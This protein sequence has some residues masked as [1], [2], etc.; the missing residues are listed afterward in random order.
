MHK[1]V[2]MFVNVDWFFFSHRAII[3]ENAQKYGIEMS[4]FTEFTNPYHGKNAPYRLFNS[5]L[6]RVSIFKISLIKQFWQAF[7][8]IKDSKP[9]LLHAVTIKPII[10]IGLIARITK[11]PFV[12]AIS[13]LG[14][15]FSQQRLQ[16]KIYRYVLTKT[17]KIIMSTDKARVICQN[18]SDKKILIELGVIEENKIFIIPGSGVNLNRFRPNRNRNEKKKIVFTN[19]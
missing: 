13:G 2:Y 1:K 14:P 7:S 11:T 12:A 18:L 10:V 15:A 3:A 4:V 9:D 19:C 8:L 6:K 16:S 17:F 5:P